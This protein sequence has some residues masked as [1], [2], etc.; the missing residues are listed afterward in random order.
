MQILNEAEWALESS[1]R[2]G[3]GDSV[4]I[5]Q[6][7]NG[8]QSDRLL[9]SSRSE[10]LSPMGP[11]PLTQTLP[12]NKWHL[13]LLVNRKIWGHRLSVG[14]HSDSV[15]VSTRIHAMMPHKHRYNAGDLSETRFLT[16]WD[17]NKITLERYNQQEKALFYSWL[18]I[19]G[20]W[21]LEAKR[22]DE[23]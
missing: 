11:N 10:R 2:K 20:H 23:K 18:G 1:L 8:S 19:K 4:S 22:F 17:N 6:R 15:S 16:Y 5:F 3:H 9:T 7:R 14:C 12:A 21:G 13:M